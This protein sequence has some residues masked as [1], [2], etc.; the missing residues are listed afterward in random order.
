M[1][2]TKREKTAKNEIIE[3]LSKQGYPTYA[4]LFSKFDLHLTT[5]PKVIAYMNVNKAEITVNENLGLE[6]IS[7]VVR[8]EILHE[9]FTHFLRSEEVRKSNPKLK[10][11]PHELVN[12]AGDYDISNKGYTDSDKQRTRSI[13]VKRGENDFN[14]LRGLVTEDDHPDW[15]DL[16][17]EEMLD[18][19]TD[20]YNENKQYVKNLIQQSDMLNPEMDP[21]EE[22]AENLQRQA[23]IEIEK[24]EE[25]AKEQK[26]E[27]NSQGAQQAEKAKDQAEE[28]KEKAQE[29]QKDIQKRDEQRA[30][31]N[32]VLKSNK[33]QKEDAELS[34]RVQEIKDLLKNPKLKD[35][36]EIE[37]IT[38]RNKEK[39]ARKAD[40][41]KRYNKSALA[42]FKISLE[43]FVRN[44]LTTKKMKTW[45]VVNRTHFGSGILAPAIA[46]QSKFEIPLINVYFDRSCSFSGYPQK[47]LRAEQ[48]ISSLNKYVKEGKLKIDLYYASTDVFKS[49]K[50]AEEKGGGMDA[51]PVIEHIKQTKPT[52]VIILT[53]SD[54]DYATIS[55]KVPGAVWYLFFGSTAPRMVEHL[56]GR[57]LT[58]VFVVESNSTW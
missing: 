58:R 45:N 15:V 32:N 44:Q 39:A 29:L 26:Q 38:N 24:A 14:V 27:G 9:F 51:D 2:M 37:T 55:A 47:T 10:D 1:G 16:S 36:A 53:D 19:L 8:H 35:K 30:N 3:L 17:F 56:K 5:N 43:D 33:E 22:E 25:E 40:D 41:L 42:K 23:Q 4:Y 6:W 12:I 18:K 31:S 46:K 21:S 49:R 11:I 7:T 20:D 54:A 34:K 48:A 57:E 28:A 52:N 13:S 50:E